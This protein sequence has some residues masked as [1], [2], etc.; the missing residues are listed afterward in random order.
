MSVGCLI[1][2][3]CK[4]YQRNKREAMNIWVATPSLAGELTKDL[5]QK[6]LPFPKFSD[7]PLHI[8]LFSRIQFQKRTVSIPVF[9][10]PVENAHF[11][12]ESPGLYPVVHF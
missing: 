3:L 6:S 8:T 5:Q 9:I 7:V 12:N 11:Y 10:L 4:N 1:C 2:F